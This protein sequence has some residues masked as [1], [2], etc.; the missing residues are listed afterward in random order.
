MKYRIQVL[1]LWWD[2]DQ[3]MICGIL[4]D[5]TGVALITGELWNS[6]PNDSLRR[7]WE[8]ID[9]IP[10]RVGRKNMTSTVSEKELLQGGMKVQIPPCL[11]VVEIE[12]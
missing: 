10:V 3:E 8:E 12:L 5:G 11:S 7:Y 2:K 9:G 6:G 4:P 1:A